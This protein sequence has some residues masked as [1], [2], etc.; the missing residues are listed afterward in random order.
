MIGDKRTFG[1]RTFVVLLSLLTLGVVGAAVASS[2][3]E[4]GAPG[5]AKSQLPANI[6][7]SK[8][9]VLDPPPVEPEPEPTL[10]EAIRFAER[11]VAE[12]RDDPWVTVCLNRDGTLAGQMS[13]DVPPGVEPPT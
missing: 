9:P 1:A 12:V 2:S 3:E 5:E 6:N 13:L 8:E 10:A 7:P 4:P 11:M